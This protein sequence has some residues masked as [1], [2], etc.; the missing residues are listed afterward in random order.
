MP[1]PR[2]PIHVRSDL[3]MH[4]RNYVKAARDTFRRSAER[5]SESLH[6]RIEDIDLENAVLVM[7]R[8]SG[9]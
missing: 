3:M 4:P 1:V 7:I 6:P 9:N 8:Q 2:S 5:E